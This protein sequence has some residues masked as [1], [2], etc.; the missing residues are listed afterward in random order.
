MEEDKLKDDIRAKWG[1]FTDYDLP[2]TE[3]T[4]EGLA[5]FYKK[6]FIYD[7]NMPENI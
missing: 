3:G 2:M 4:E 7:K 6:R 1:Q 5:D